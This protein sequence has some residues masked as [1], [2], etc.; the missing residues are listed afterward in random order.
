MDSHLVMSDLAS[1]KL[2]NRNELYGPSRCLARDAAK[3]K[4]LEDHMQ[5]NF[6]RGAEIVHSTHTFQTTTAGDFGVRHD[7]LDYCNLTGKLCVI[8]G[9]SQ[10]LSKVSQS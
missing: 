5:Q 7:I 10:G 4:Q 3:Q 1:Q 6:Q 9:L 2:Q 8:V